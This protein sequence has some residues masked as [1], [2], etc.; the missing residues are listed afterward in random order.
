MNQVN[1]R[2]INVLIAD[3]HPIVSEGLS[4]YMQLDP[5]I[6]I[7]AVCDSNEELSRVTDCANIDVCLL[8]LEL[9]DGLS[10]SLIPQ[11]VKRG[12]KVVVLTSCSRAEFLK[13]AV[14]L[15]AISYVSKSVQPNKLVDIVKD[16]SLGRRYLQPE[17]ITDESLVLANEALTNKEIEILVFVAQGYSNAEI[18]D[19]ISVSIK[20]VRFHMSNILGKLQLT[21]RTQ[22][23]ILAWQQKLVS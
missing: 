10:T 11:I 23:A 16:A 20:T 2:M 13:Q 21:D 9:K 15:G 5:D 18:A 3:D 17:L 8:D 4:T 19:V 14:D 6:N 12:I 7:V 1:G 22:A